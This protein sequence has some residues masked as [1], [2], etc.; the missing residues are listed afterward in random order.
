MTLMLGKKEG[1]SLNA[2]RKEIVID[3]LIIGVLSKYP[4]LSPLM[5]TVL[6]V[7]FS[8]CPFPPTL[9]FFLL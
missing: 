7:I 9:L 2:H 4:V 6:I 1:Y 5:R 8:S 3:G